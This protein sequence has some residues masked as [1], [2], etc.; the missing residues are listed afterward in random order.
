LSRTP[1]GGDPAPASDRPSS[2]GQPG[3]LYGLIARYPRAAAIGGASAISFSGFLY[4][5]SGV[6][7]ATATFF[8]AFYALPWLAVMAWLE[9]RQGRPMPR[10]AHLLAILAGVCFGTEL[11][12]WTYSID[13]A[14]TGVATV[15]VNLQVVIVGFA[16]WFIFKERPSKLMIGA[17][18][19]M[20]VGVAL[21]SGAIG[22]GAYGKNPVLGVGLGLL[23]SFGWAGYL[24]VT[25]FAGGI[26]HRPAT[27]LFETT[28]TM[29]FICAVVGLFTGTLNVVPSWPEHGWLVLYAFTSQV[30]AYILIGRSLPLLP[31][32]LTSMILLAQPIGTVVVGLLFLGETPSLLQLA[33]V[34]L[35]IAGLLIANLG[36]RGRPGPPKPV[37]R[38]PSA[39]MSPSAEG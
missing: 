35:I 37:M 12:L 22:G 13:N 4:R 20:L 36:K 17:L 1:S 32:M 3:G 23:G 30:I 24:I 39:S 7:A 28:S 33:G 19:I 27:M 5:H 11:L 34:G 29:A 8:R 38:N 31:A 10:R 15:L 21:I 14:G 26:V 18:P 6:P 9:H 25:R 16:A 2:N